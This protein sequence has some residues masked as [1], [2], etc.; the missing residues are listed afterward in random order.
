MHETSISSKRQKFISKRRLK[1][2]LCTV[3]I[4]AIAFPLSFISPYSLQVVEDDFGEVATVAGENLQSY[5]SKA[6]GTSGDH[7]LSALKNISI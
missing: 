2:H 6:V 7:K 1:N 4:S 5:L 3:E